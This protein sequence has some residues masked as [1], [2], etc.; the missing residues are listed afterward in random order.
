MPQNSQA[1]GVENQVFLKSS[2]S[3]ASRPASLINLV[4][5]LVLQLLLVARHIGLPAFSSRLEFQ[6]R[7]RSRRNDCKKKVFFLPPVVGS[8]SFLQSSSRLQRILPRVGNNV[9]RLVT[10]ESH[11]RCTYHDEI[12]SLV[13]YAVDLIS[14]AIR[15]VCAFS[16][17]KN[18]YYT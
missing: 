12:L 18:R 3:N 11:E 5:Y 16:E 8:L 2:G 14:G 10:R 17:D 15:R 4:V 1:I 9:I 6:K 7:A 13:S